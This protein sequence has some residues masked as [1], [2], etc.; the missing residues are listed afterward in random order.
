MCHFS[1]A[2]QFAVA[3]LMFMFP[4]WPLQGRPSIPTAH[5]FIFS[6][7]MRDYLDR[8]FL[9]L[10]AKKMKFTFLST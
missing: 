3:V 4:S 5:I 6:L 2:G 10:S 1:V 8:M 9:N 7:C